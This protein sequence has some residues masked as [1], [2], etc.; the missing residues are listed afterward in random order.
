MQA[1]SLLHRRWP[2]R[3]LLRLLRRLLL[4]CDVLLQEGCVRAGQLLLQVVG[5]RNVCRRGWLRRCPSGLLLG[6]C[7]TLLLLLCALQQHLLIHSRRPSCHVQLRMA[8]GC[9]CQLVLIHT[10]QHA[11][12]DGQADGCRRRRPR[13]RGRL[14]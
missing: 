8:L 7:C 3:R 12:L 1:P 2:C 11:L 6:F 9:G 10:Q 14:C 13:A 5:Y 4:R